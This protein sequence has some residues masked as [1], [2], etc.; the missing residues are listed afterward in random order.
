[1]KIIDLYQRSKCHVMFNRVNHEKII[2]IK[3]LLPHEQIIEDNHYKR[4][5]IM[6]DN[7]IKEYKGLYKRI[8][9]MNGGN[10][11]FYITVRKDKDYYLDF[12][13]VSII[14][15]L[16]Q[17]ID[18][19][20]ISNNCIKDMSFFDDCL[21]KALNDRYGLFVCKNEEKKI[22]ILLDS[23]EKQLYRINIQPNNY[24][25]DYSLN[26]CYSLSQNYFLFKT[27]NAK[28]SQKLELLKKGFKENGKEQ[29][30]LIDLNSFV[31]QVKK[32]ESIEYKLIEIKDDYGSIDIINANEKYIIY[33]DIDFEEE[34]TNIIKY[35][36]NK[37]NREVL[38]SLN[39]V[40]K[41]AAFRYF[42]NNIY[43][44]TDMLDK[45]EIKNVFT[46]KKYFL[47]YNHIKPSICY[48]DEKILI[49]Q[50]QSYYD[51]WN[52]SVY[53]VINNIEIEKYNNRQ[54]T[55]VEDTESLI[56]H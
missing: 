35:Y 55:Y 8:D 38:A 48:F 15:E 49:K 11:L 42:N 17:L 36:I 18:S 51:S 52:V 53:D 14:N 1:M 21:F 24:L 34:K 9:A 27:G 30:I 29:L 43:K 31:K 32:N 7:S 23:I 13:R 4:F 16:D 26:Y 2:G 37:N 41:R 10:S 20:K 54:G 28:S 6:D 47:F 19:M 39:R 22:A 40:Y 45:L 5:Y 50:L 56:L 25:F 44:I 12:Y 33:L 3:K 46:D